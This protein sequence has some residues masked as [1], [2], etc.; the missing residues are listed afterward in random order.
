MTNGS[1]G[2]VLLEVLQSEDW[3][4]I[5]TL[6]LS[7]KVLLITRLI[8]GVSVDLGTFRAQLS[9]DDPFTLPR[10]TG[11]VDMPHAISSREG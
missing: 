9:H 1:R 6:P 4:Q 7:A 8:D 3:G 2:N 11:S 10:L 5:D